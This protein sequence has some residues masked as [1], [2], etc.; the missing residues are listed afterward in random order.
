MTWVWVLLAIIVAFALGY[1]MFA[2][3]RKT[4]VRE[5]HVEPANMRNNSID[6]MSGRMDEARDEKLRRIA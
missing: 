6:A 3:K 2:P 1:M 5:E 4:D